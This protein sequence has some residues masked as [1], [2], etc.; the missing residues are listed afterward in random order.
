[1]MAPVV[2]RKGLQ[3]IIGLEVLFPMSMIR[4]ST[5]T[6]VMCNST[7]TSLTFP[8][9]CLMESSASASS[10]E[11]FSIFLSSRTSYSSL[12]NIE[13]QDP[14]SKMAWCVSF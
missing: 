7:I 13:T 11:H 6:K 10:I 9:A 8:R 1:M 14:R 4:K 2:Q 12:D 3:R 5:G